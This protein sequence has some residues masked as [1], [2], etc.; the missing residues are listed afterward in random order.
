M[1]L[2]PPPWEPTSPTPST[3]PWKWKPGQSGNPAG[4]AKG[5]LNKK[6][7][8]AKALD[9]RAEDVAKAMIAKALEGDT[10]AGRLVL[11]RVQAPKRSEGTRVNFQLNT[12]ASV[13][14]QARQVLAAMASGEVDV[15]IGQIFLNSLSTFSGLIEHTELAK[16]ITELEANARAGAAA[17]DVLGRVMQTETT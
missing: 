6:T 4:K 16:R 17:Q 5:T 11:E 3:D 12:D 1:A 9:E 10:S 7:L 15:E 14:D 13:A 2:I 8:V